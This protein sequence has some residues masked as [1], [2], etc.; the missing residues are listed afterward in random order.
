MWFRLVFCVM[1]KVLRLSDIDIPAAPCCTPPTPPPR[2]RH[3]LLCN[4][5]SIYIKRRQDNHNYCQLKERVHYI[6]DFRSICTSWP[7][8]CARQRDTRAVKIVN[9]TFKWIHCR[10]ELLCELKNRLCNLHLFE[11]QTLPLRA[12]PRRPAPRRACQTN[13]LRYKRQSILMYSDPNYRCSLYFPFHN[14]YCDYTSIIGT[15]G[16]LIKTSFAII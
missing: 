3:A 13:L 5:L 8:S 10:A 1:A 14:A 12:V 4:A 7:F 11:K 6:L 16:I 9:S 15:F 2:G